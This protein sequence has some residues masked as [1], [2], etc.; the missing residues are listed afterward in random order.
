MATGNKLE[1]WKSIIGYEGIY[2]ISNLG[3]VKSLSRK[4][5]FLNTFRIVK[6]KL[7]KPNTNRYGYITVTLSNNCDMKTVT[8]HRLLANAFID[9][10]EGKEY[11]NHIDGIKSNNTIKNLEWCT[12]KEN[13]KHSF[14]NGLNILPNGVNH[15]NS[16]FSVN[17]ILSIRKSD[18][19]ESKLALIYKVNRA[20]IGKI[21]RLERYKNI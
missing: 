6:E 17:D 8:I 9:K 10:V 20:T 14:D 15:Y 5:Y 1:Y 3:S 12:I 13:N 4:I 7:L 19:S 16:R 11:V 2:E 21:K 18:L